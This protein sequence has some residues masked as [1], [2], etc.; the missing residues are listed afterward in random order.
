MGISPPRFKLELPRNKYLI[1][2][3]VFVHNNYAMYGEK[4]YFLI[5]YIN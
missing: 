3:H 1:L 4:K 5:K 2:L